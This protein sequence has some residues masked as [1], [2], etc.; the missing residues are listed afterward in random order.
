MNS[1]ETKAVLAQLRHAKVQ[2]TKAAWQC[3]RRAF[4]AGARTVAQLTKGLSLVRDGRNNLWAVT[5]RE[6]AQLR[7][8]VLAAGGRI[9]D[10]VEE[11]CRGVRPVI[12]AGCTLATIA[13]GLAAAIA[14]ARLL[15]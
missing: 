9:R 8:Q 5:P 2:P 14:L 4:D 11:A 15:P 10:A 3:I 1:R 12:V 13:L 6:D 7:A